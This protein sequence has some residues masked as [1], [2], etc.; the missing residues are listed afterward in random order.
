[1]LRY[2]CSGCSLAR[3]ST[4][5]S[6]PRQQISRLLLRSCAAHCTLVSRAAVWRRPSRV[7]ISRSTRPVSHLRFTQWLAWHNRQGDLVEPRRRA[8]SIFVVSVGLIILWLLV[9]EIVGRM[10]H[11]LA[12]S[13]M[14]AATGLFTGAFVISTLLFG[15]RHP[16]VFS[17]AVPGGV[18]T[19]VPA[20]SVIPEPLDA[21]IGHALA[22]MM[23]DDRAY[24]DPELTIGII[25][26]RVET[27][28][29]RVRRHI[30]RGLGYRNVSDYLNEHRITEVRS[31]LVDPEQAN[32]SILTIAMDAGFG[33]LVMFNRVFKERLGETPSAFRRRH[34]EG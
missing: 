18:R 5:R 27:P 3:G 26:A 29:Y 4:M 6:D 32:V 34:L 25:A 30:N 14:A 2:R 15:L 28:E 24:R 10:T 22:K 7:W 1:M 21:S 20:T 31:A 19:E 11:E 9:S 23:T 12:L 13:G 17:T 16:E 8:R 33:S